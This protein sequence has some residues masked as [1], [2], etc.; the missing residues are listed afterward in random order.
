MAAPTI[1]TP[2]DNP[3][4]VQFAV[5]ADQ[6]TG[7]NPSFFEVYYDGAA[8]SSSTITGPD[9]ALFAIIDL[10]PGVS[11]VTVNSYPLSVG[12]YDITANID[13]GAGVDSVQLVITV[14]TASPFYGVLD[15]R[16]NVKW[17]LWHDAQY[18][19]G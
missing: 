11:V 7:V 10:D 19:N 17:G 2:A 6:V 16:I 18:P 14:G 5:D 13:N 9:S 4:A 8:A 15:P 1:T 12:T 3:H